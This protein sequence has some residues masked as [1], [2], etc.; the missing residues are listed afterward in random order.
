MGEQFDMFRTEALP[1]RQP[2]ARAKRAAP[3]PA[4]RHEVLDEAALVSM[5]EA[6]GRY[7]IL[8]RLEPRSIVPRDKSRFPCL[9][10]I[11]DTETT[12]LDHEKNEIIELGMVAVTYDPA[13]QV[14]DVVGIFNALRQP[15]EPIPPE[16]TRLTGITDAMVAGKT[17]STAEVEAFIEPADLV[18][19]HNARFDRPFCERFTPGFAPKPWACSNVEIAWSDRGFEGTKLGYLLGQSGYF[20]NGHR[21]VDDCHA[22]LEVLAR[23]NGPGGTAP[24][25]E[26][27]K[28]SER[29]RI[30]I[31]ATNSPFDMKE[32]LKAR[33]YRWNDGSNG[34]P[35]SW[36]T[37]VDEADA[38][39]ELKFLRAEIYQWPEARPLTQ[40]LAATDR[41]KA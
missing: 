22:L 5:L 36:W 33:G 17:I 13:G 26:L 40:R 39:A 34:Q 16:I 1:E 41:F 31:S 21:A 19:A 11:V 18:I 9:A 32:R 23:P 15:R 24:F 7:R 4:R 12:G 8:R 3:A 10:V 37:E 29:A 25:A 6:T 38:E 28:A 27:L 14:G 35:K 30:R 20:H 2:A